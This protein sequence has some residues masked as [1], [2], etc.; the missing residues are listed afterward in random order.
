MKPELSVL[1]ENENELLNFAKTI[2]DHICLNSI[3]LLAGDLSAGK[4]TFVSY[5]CKTFGLEFVQSP[6][7]SIHQRYQN[8]LVTIDHFD[9]YR[10]NT[11]DEIESSGFYDLLAEKSD[12]QIIEWPERL[13]LADL[14]IGS[15]KF[16]LQFEVLSSTRRH[17]NLFKIKN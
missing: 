2:Q 13:N 9:L 8:N 11:T 5:F 7:Y 14:P 4:T 17:L 10:L 1:V 15:N 12:Y 16:L 6:T 3:I